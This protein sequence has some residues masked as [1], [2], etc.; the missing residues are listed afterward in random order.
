[1][2]NSR[3]KTR[4][5][6]DL[7]KETENTLYFWVWNKGMY[8]TIG[9]ADAVKSLEVRES[10]YWRKYHWRA[11]K[12]IYLMSRISAMHV[13]FKKKLLELSQLL[14]LSAAPTW[15]QW[16]SAFRILYECLSSQ[17]LNM[18]SALGNVFLDS[19]LEHRKVFRRGWGWCWVV[20]GPSGIIS[21]VWNMKSLVWEFKHFCFYSKSIGNTLT[22]FKKGAI[23]SF[24]IF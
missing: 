14:M 6:Q 19:L 8:A 18:Q 7:V 11:G 5:S 9:R 23:W 13:F 21:E 24:C 2:P 15:E 17:T 1:M 3:L 22:G 20:I 12:E 4:L 10:C 16:I